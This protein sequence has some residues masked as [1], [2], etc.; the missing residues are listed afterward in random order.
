M[1][2][3]AGEPAELDSQP[4]EA[5][6]AVAPQE[7]PKNIAHRD[8]QAEMPDGGRSAKKNIKKT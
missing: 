7:Q 1:R 6:V 4:D 2:Q 8:H 5:E 3:H